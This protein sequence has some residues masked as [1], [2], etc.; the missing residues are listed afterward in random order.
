MQKQIIMQ[1]ATQAIQ[2]E[3]ASA[4]LGADLFKSASIIGGH[5]SAQALEQAS[6]EQ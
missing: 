3:W 2:Q 1:V 6:S 4:R 5:L